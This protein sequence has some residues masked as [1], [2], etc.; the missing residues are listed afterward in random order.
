MA[1]WKKNPFLK[2]AQAPE[3]VRHFDPDDD[4]GGDE[5]RQRL[6]EAFLEAA[7]NQIQDYPP[8]REAYERMVAEGMHE[9]DAR[10]YIANLVSRQVH[11]VLTKNVTYNAEL[12]HKWLR[13]LP[14]LPED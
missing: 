4:L 14:N 11:Y 13:D 5:G 9:T 7:D 2:A 10:F 12:H 8:A 1:N 3:P 6:R